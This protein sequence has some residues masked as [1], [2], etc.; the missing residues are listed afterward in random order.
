MEESHKMAVSVRVTGQVQGVS[1]RAWT[2]ATADRLGLR[3]WVRNE[4]YGS[5]IAMLSGPE[6]AVT[7]MIDAMWQG[8]AA[9]SVR[10][11]QVSPDKTEAPVDFE[12]RH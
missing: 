10:D 2:K 1:Y 4:P 11:V 3:G 6:S 12:I 9:A 7:Q 5:V 8:P